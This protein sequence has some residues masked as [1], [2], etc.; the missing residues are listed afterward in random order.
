MSATLY[1]TS[2]AN[3]ARGY[4]WHNVWSATAT[5]DLHDVLADYIIK[6]WCS[7][8]PQHYQQWKL[9]AS[10]SIPALPRASQAALQAFMKRAFGQDITRSVR[11]ADQQDIQ[12]LVGEC[13]WHYLAHHQYCINCNTHMNPVPICPTDKGG[14][15]Y[16]IHE[17]PTGVLNFR[18]WEI[19]KYA[20]NRAVTAAEKRR[21]FYA[22]KNAAVTQLDQK[23]D[24][25]L[26]ELTAIFDK[27]HNPD[28]ALLCSTLLEDWASGATHLGAGCSISTT[29]A[30]IPT[31]C[32]RTFKTRLTHFTHPDAK[33]GLAIGVDDYLAFVDRVWKALWKGL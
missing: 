3:P 27:R 17:D 32:F 9:K 20:G 30:I 19:K 4:T 14:D 5:N 13:L 1:F 8:C 24:V 15:A 2:T 29:Q 23:A 25:Y 6:N 7:G 18:L 22:R 11:I 10:G 33:L 21:G 12:G 26:A 28:L 31:T 16:T